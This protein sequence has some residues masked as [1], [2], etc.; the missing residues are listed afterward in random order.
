MPERHR[1]ITK[2]IGE[3]LME[4]G[5]ITKEQLQEALEI[6]R[7]NKKLLGEILVDLGYATEEEVMTSI[8]TQYGVAFLPLENYEIDPEIIKSVSADLVHKYS[9]IPVDRICGLLTIVISDVP[10]SESVSK[11]EEA[12]GCKVES[13]ITTS[14]ALRKA[15]EKYYKG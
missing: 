6:Q 14:S 13:F 11:I 12:L 15:I 3:L 10:D 8:T 1:I 2:R 5:V 9:F 7:E 4:R